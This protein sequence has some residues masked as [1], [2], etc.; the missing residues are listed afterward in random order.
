MAWST[1]DRIR[2]VQLYYREGSAVAAQ[3]AFR[4]ELGRR[5]APE[6]RTLLQW[7]RNFEATGTVARMPHHGGR[8]RVPRSVVVAVKRAIRRN[9]RLSTRRLSLRI[10]SPRSTIQ[11]I[12]RQQLGLHPY[13]LQLLQRLKRGDKARRLSFCKRA[14]LKWR[15]RTFRKGLIMTDEAPVFPGWKGAEADLPSLGRAE[16]PLSC[17]TGGLQPFDNCVVR[18]LPNVGMLGPFFFEEEGRPVRARYR[19]LLLD[20]VVPAID[21]LQLPRNQVWFQQDGATPHTAR[22]VLFVCRGSFPLGLGCR[23]KVVPGLI[24]FSELGLRIGV[25]WTPSNWPK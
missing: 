7:V 23:V 21:E 20:R 24:W 14:L 8:P 12:L 3:R 1:N 9:P 2:A 18:G 5:M 22:G 11:R 10:G 19:S 13:K 17:R 4:R 25:F 15:S 6:R 16:P